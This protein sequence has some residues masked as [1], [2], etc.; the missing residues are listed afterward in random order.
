M[1]AETSVPSTAAADRGRP[2]RFQLHRAASAR[3]RGSGGRPQAPG[4]VHRLHRQPRPD[5]LP[6]GDHRQLRRRGAGRLLRPHR[7]D[8]PRRRLGRGPRQ[9]PRHPRR[10]RAQ[11]RALRRRG[12]DD[13]AA[14]RRKVRRRLLR[15]LRRPA[16][17]RRLRRQ[18][19]VRAARRRGRPQRQDA[20]PSASA[21]AC[22]ASSPSRAPTPRSTP[23]TACARARGSPRRRTGT[24]VRYWADRQIFLKDAKLS[25]ETLYARARQTAF[26]VPGLTLVVRDERGLDGRR[27][28]RGGLPLRRRHQR[29]LR[30]PRAGQGRLRRA[31]ADRP[32]HL[33]GDRAGPGRPRPH[34][35]HRGHARTR[36][37]H[38]A[39][40]GHRL[41]HD[42]QVLRQHHRDAQGRHPRLRLRA[43]GH[44]DRQRGAAVQRSCCASPRTTSS[45]TTRWRASPPS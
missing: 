31:A 8:P 12:R 29:V 13:Q 20:T 11:D 26:L 5:A 34:D 39:A 45:R 19:A 23:P 30:V 25:L 42:G 2:G 44:Q 24:R 28:D 6:V 15:G 9:R 22:P 35:A 1:T 43:L 18:R 14:R 7:G 10:R 16:R 3:P 27:Q 38:R 4:H 37:R 21:A 40:L 33:Q 41:R 36:R 17:R 32:G